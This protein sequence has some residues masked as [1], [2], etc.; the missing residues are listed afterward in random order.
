[1]LSSSIPTDK[2]PEGT[3]PVRCR[4]PP[5]LAIGVRPSSLIERSRRYCTTGIAITVYRLSLTNER[6]GYPTVADRHQWGTPPVG[7]QR[8][9]GGSSLWC[10]WW[11]RYRDAWTT[12]TRAQTLL[13]FLG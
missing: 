9:P 7:C 3:I 8:W 13:A 5:D 1:M 11:S 4:V 6:G 2:L 10:P 12:S